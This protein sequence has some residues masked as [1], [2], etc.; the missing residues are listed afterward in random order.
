MTSEKVSG[1]TEKK[2]WDVVDSCEGGHPSATSDNELHGGVPT[3]CLTEGRRYDIKG[4]LNKTPCG[5]EMKESMSLSTDN[6]IKDWNA[7][8]NH[9]QH[10][11]VKWMGPQKIQTT[12]TVTIINK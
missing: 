5:N 4:Q 6:N 3:T 1:S 7:M 10:M 12:R 8:N 2:L 11:E 9:T